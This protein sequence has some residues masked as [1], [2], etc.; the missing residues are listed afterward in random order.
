MAFVMEDLTERLVAIEAMADH[1]ST[2]MS[3]S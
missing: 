1:R 2:S 3:S